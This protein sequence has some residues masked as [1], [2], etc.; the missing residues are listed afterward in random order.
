MTCLAPT[1]TMVWAAVQSSPFSRLSLSAIASRSG[2]MPATGVYLVSPRTIAATAACFTLSGVSKSGSPNVSVITDLPTA[3][4]SRARC[5]ATTVAE[6]C[7]RASA[8]E[9]I[10]SGLHLF[11]SGSAHE[12][13]TGTLPRGQGVSQD[14]FEA[15]QLGNTTRS[16]A[17]DEGKRHYELGSYRPLLFP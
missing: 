2:A 8:A 1:P 6:G 13:V 17:L 15:R 4:R 7:I 3:A 12:N 5:V 9:M 11:R 16:V 14:K 10:V